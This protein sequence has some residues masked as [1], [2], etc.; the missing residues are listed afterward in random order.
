MTENGQKILKMTTV[1][2]ARLERN[3]AFSTIPQ[4]TIFHSHWCDQYAIQVHLDTQKN[5]SIIHKRKFESTK[6][7]AY[8]TDEQIF[9]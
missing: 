8:H 1:A 9:G 2:R 7:F 4:A 5:I 6:E 3:I